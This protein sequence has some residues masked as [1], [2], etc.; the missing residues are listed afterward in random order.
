[1]AWTLPPVLLCAAA[2][3]LAG[4][5]GSR[6]PER[7]ARVVVA[8]PVHFLQAEGEA[9]AP[10]VVSRGVLKV[11]RQGCLRLNNRAL[12]WPAGAALDLSQPGAVRVFNRDE[13]VS[14]RVGEPV[15]LLGSPETDPSAPA[16]PGPRLQV[17][18][19]LA[20]A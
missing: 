7:A 19:M 17:A 15:A 6:A 14:V 11:D 18:S 12:V 20:A 4:C 10:A 3:L 13:G 9:A 5:S 2:A 16:C 1:M 8:G